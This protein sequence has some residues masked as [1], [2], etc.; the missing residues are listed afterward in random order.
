[1]TARTQPVT[2]T[3]LL[4]I[5]EVRQGDDVAKILLTALQHNEIQLVDGDILVVSSKVVSKAPVVT[6]YLE[7]VTRG[8][9]LLGPLDLIDAAIL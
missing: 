1:M 2:L 6:K 3:P 7:H 4:G 9:V 8:N 5:P